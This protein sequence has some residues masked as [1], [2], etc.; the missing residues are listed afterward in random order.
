M[1]GVAREQS[2]KCG[3]GSGADLALLVED[4]LE[5][6]VVVPSSTVSTVKRGQ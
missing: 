2:G 6:P 5:V 3:R 4:P 1:G